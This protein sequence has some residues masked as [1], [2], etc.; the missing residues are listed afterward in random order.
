LK[1]MQKNGI[2]KTKIWQDNIKMN[3][4]KIVNWIVLAEDRVSCLVSV[5]CWKFRVSQQD[6]SSV[7]HQMTDGGIFLNW[8]V[9]Q[10]R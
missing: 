1:T 5:K 9:G 7:E 2:Q 8:V 3:P 6:M 4:Q 10:L